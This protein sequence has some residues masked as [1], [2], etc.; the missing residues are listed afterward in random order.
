MYWW[1]AVG[2]HSSCKKMTGTEKNGRNN[3]RERS[4]VVSK[5][6]LEEKKSRLNGVRS[7]DSLR[8]CCKNL[9]AYER[10]RRKLQSWKKHVGR[11]NG[12]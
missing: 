11:R 7:R 8:T 6:R 10:S 3:F 2:F 12:S 1:T 9:N 4:N 5:R